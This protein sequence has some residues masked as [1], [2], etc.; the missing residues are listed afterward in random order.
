MENREFISAA[1]LPNTEAEEVDVLCVENGEMKRKI[2]INLGGDE[3]ADLVLALAM[4]IG[5]GTATEENT[6]VTI[7]SGSLEAVA[8]AFEAGRPPVVKCKRY[9]LSNGFDTSFPIAEGGVYDGNVIYYGGD[10]TFAF[11]VPEA[12][13][14][15]I[16]MNIDDAEYLEVWRYTLVKSGGQVI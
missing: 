12:Y 13:V 10:L 8:A 15:R 16:V 9:H 7:E 1:D 2:G 3:K 5:A 14:V 4:P 6:S 11:F